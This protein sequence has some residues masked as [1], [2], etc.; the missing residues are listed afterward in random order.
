MSNPRFT[1]T[2]REEEIGEI[3]EYTEQTGVQRNELIRR[4]TLAYVRL[5]SGKGSDIKKLFQQVGL[6][7]EPPATKIEPVEQAIHD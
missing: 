4:A 3:K 5:Q 7:D 2:M 1:V 6:I